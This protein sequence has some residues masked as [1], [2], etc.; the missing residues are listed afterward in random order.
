M[1]PNLLPPKQE[2]THGIV[3][4]VVAPLLSTTPD[5][6]S[7]AD[8]DSRQQ[9]GRGGGKAGGHSGG[10]APAA[11]PV[12]VARDRRLWDL[13]PK[14]RT[15]PPEYYVVHTWGARLSEVVEQLED[16]LIPKVSL[17]SQ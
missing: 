15:G 1:C 13:V 3:R 6:A 7:D 4:Q 16:C 5:D 11:A 10:S 2:D 14:A 8:R 17:E 12:V 9:Q